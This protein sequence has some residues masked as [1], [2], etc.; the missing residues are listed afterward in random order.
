MDKQLKLEI[1]DIIKELE[2]KNLIV[3]NKKI[4]NK[5]IYNALKYYT[6]KSKNDLS[7]NL[8]TYIDMKVEEMYSQFSNKLNFEVKHLNRGIYRVILVGTPFSIYCRFKRKLFENVENPTGWCIEF[9]GETVHKTLGKKE[10]IDF[11]KS[12]LEDKFREI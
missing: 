8:I 12:Y 4:I 1:E 3:P 11:A 5:R 7:D 10:A 2:I 9:N 6:G